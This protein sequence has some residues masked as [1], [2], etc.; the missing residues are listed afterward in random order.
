MAETHDMEIECV[1]DTDDQGREGPDFMHFPNCTFKCRITA[2]SHEEGLRQ[3]RELH[4][5]ARAEQEQERERWLEE[6]KTRAFPDWECNGP[7]I[8][9]CN[10]F[11]PLAYPD[12]CHDCF[13]EASMPK[14]Y[15]EE[16]ARAMAFFA[17]F[18][19]QGMSRTIH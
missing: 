17:N 3:I 11:E 2:S 14:E 10:H 19:L 18:A 6:N 9:I 8:T 7:Q 5:K 12:P 13:W 1:G 15:K 4:Q 16:M